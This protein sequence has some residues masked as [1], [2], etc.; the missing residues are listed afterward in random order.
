[1]E[2]TPYDA[3]GNI[4]AFEQGDLDEEGTLVLFQHLVDTGLAWS[5]QGSYGRMA[6]GLID[7]GF[8]AA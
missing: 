5:L 1:M 6:Q 2:K 3:V 8:I 7:A 4:M